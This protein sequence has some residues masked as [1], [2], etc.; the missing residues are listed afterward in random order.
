MTIVIPQFDL[1]RQLERLDGELAEAH[2]RVLHSGQFILGAEVEAFERAWADACGVAHAVGVASGT[3]ALELALRAA[4]VG[5]GDE[6]ITV[7]HTFVATALAITAVGAVPV[8]V[9]VGLQDGLID[10]ELIEAALTAR[11]RA[12]IP[13]HLYGR[14][15]NLEP[16]LRIAAEHGLRVIEDAAQAH[17]A[18]HRDR[19]AGA[20]GD[21]GCFS[22]YPTKNLG[23]LGD[24]GAVV[25]NDAELAASLRRL[26][27]YGEERKYHHVTPGRNSRLD[28]LQAAVLSVKLAHLA[29]FNQAR[30]A[31]AAR[32]RAAVPAGGPLQFLA[33]DPKADAMHQAVVCARD[34]DGLRRHLAAAGIATQIHYPV[35]CHCQPALGRWPARAPL[36]VTER[37]ADEVLSL[38][39]YPE[40]DDAQVVS[41]CA[42]LAAWCLAA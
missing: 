11:T 33:F 32:Y 10:P 37:L 39:M 42:A 23:A 15:A 5:A 34:R 25:T 3:D 17:G 19:A 41:V 18:R 38:P 35:P 24:A 13:V 40:L 6:V 2:A 9:D 31:I 27:N 30:G 26:R 4:G 20:W 22:F 8:Y 36:P 7:A 29:E 12:I 21:L 1:R 16:V 14:C 28:E